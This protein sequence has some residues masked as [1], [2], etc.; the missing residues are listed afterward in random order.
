VGCS[1]EMETCHLDSN[2]NLQPLLCKAGYFKTVVKGTTVQSCQ[3][4]N[5]THCDTCQPLPSGPT[6]TSCTRCNS[7]S[8]L[9]LNGTCLPC[10]SRC[11]NCFLNA[12]GQAECSQCAPSYGLSQGECVACLAGCLACPNQVCSSCNA[13]TFLGKEG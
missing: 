4:C 12:T 9:L 7:V 13:T 1:E 2:D 8:A 10:P 6:R 5:L 3:P 11:F